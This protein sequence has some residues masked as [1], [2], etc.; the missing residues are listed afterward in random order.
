MKFNRKK[1]STDS[2][3]LLREKT[4]HHKYLYFLLYCIKLFTHL[5]IGT[6]VQQ[7]WH[8]FPLEQPLAIVEISLK[9]KRIEV[10]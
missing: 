1:F 4:V 6:E 7:Q 3:D 5:Y 2:N 8:T 9:K 10:E